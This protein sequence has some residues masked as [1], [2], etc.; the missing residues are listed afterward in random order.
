[1]RLHY[2]ALNFN[3][4][5]FFAAVL[6]CLLVTGVDADALDDAVSQDSFLAVVA[7]ALAVYDIDVTSNLNDRNIVGQRIR[8]PRLG[9]FPD[10][11]LDSLPS[12]AEIDAKRF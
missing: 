3:R 11:P 9:R 10:L 12:S 1:M 4:L 2:S 7:E 5:R 8:R 6:S